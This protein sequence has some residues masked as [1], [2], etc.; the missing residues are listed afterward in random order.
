MADETEDGADLLI[1][2]R[3]GIEFSEQNKTLLNYSLRIFSSPTVP[4]LF[5]AFQIAIIMSSS[6]CGGGLTSSPAVAVIVNAQESL[7]PIS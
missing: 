2:A 4:D 3:R 7:A 1:I 6:Y 5:M